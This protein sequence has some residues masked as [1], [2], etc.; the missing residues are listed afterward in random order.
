GTLNGKWPHPAEPN[1]SGRCGRSRYPCAGTTS[2]RVGYIRASSVTDA[3][4]QKKCR[5]LVTHRDPIQLCLPV[6]DSGERCS[7]LG[8]EIRC[9]CGIQI[10]ESAICCLDRC[11]LCRCTRWNI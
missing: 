10:S 1:S 2:R 8:I 9:L 6:R 5:D 7:I 11:G 3:R 4:R